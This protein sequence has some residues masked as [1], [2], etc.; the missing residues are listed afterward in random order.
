M[1]PCAN[2]GKREG[3]IQ[4][5]GDSGALG[6]VHGFFELWCEACVLDLQIKHAEERANALPE[7]RKRRAELGDE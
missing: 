4:Y 7:L 2:C 6:L 1:T 5:V 3:T